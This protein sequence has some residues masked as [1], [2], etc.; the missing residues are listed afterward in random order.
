MTKVK[1]SKYTVSISSDWQD[2]TKLDTTTY[3][4]VYYEYDNK[5]RIAKQ[6]SKDI[7]KGGGTIKSFYNKDG[8]L[9]M[10]TIKKNNQPIK[11]IL[12]KKA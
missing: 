1:T 8:T 10:K 12:Y 7:M 2:K 3:D 11:T 9:K 4:P 6:E 5:G